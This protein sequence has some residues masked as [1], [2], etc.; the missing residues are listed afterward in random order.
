MRGYCMAKRNKSRGKKKSFQKEAKIL[1]ENEE[2]KTESLF[3]K[4]DNKFE[5]LKKGEKK[6]HP[7]SSLEQM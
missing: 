5:L 3:G 6:H 1:S 7:E 4:Y 2:H